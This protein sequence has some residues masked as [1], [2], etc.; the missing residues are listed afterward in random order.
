LGKVGEARANDCHLRL[1]ERDHQRHAPFVPFDVWPSHRVGPGN[2]TF[3]GGL[4]Q[5]G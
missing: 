2:S 5:Q 3:V 4:V 1:R